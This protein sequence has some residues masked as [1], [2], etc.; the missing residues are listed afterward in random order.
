MAS[1]WQTVRIFISSTFRDMQT[2]R[3]HL[4]RFVFPRLR[5]ELFKWRIHLVDVDL[6]W[7]VTDEQDALEVCREVIDEC[8]LF[9][10]VLG[11]RYGWIPPGHEQSITHDEVT[12]AAFGHPENRNCHFFF[13]RRDHVTNELAKRDA[14]YAEPSGSDEAKQLKQLKDEIVIANKYKAIDYGQWDAAQQ[15]LASLDEFGNEVFNHLLNAIEQ[16]FAGESTEQLDEFAEENAAMDQF[17]S[18]RVERYVPVDSRQ[19]LL[20]DLETFAT[21]D[22]EQNILPITGEPGSGKSALLASYVAEVAKLQTSSEVSRTQ[23]LK[24][25]PHFIGASAGSTDLRRMLRRLCHEL[26]DEVDSIPHETKELIPRFA[27]LLC[28]VP[29]SQRVV[30]VIDALDQ[31]DAT[32]NAHTLFWLPQKEKLPPHVRIIA[33]SLEHPALEALTAHPACR[34]PLVIEPLQPADARAIIHSV[35][36]RYH[37]R[38]EPQQIDLLLAKTDSGNPLYLLAALEELRTLGIYDEIT[39]RIEQLPQRTVD[40]F[41]WILDRLSKD[42]G[43]RDAQGKR[44]G[45]DLVPK[46][47]SLLAVSRYG[48]S[49]VELVG[50]INPHHGDLQGNVAALERLLRSYLMRRGDLLA[51]YHGQ[52][53]F[54]V[55][56]YYLET[57]EQLRKA[58]EEV[59]HFFDSHVDAGP[60]KIQELPWQ[61][62]RLNAWSRLKACLCN[63]EVFL[64]WRGETYEEWVRDADFP[65]DLITY[66]APLGAHYDIRAEMR[67]F[68]DVLSQRWN[69]SIRSLNALHK[70]GS[71]LRCLGLPKD[72]L[73]SY[74]QAL[75][76]FDALQHVSLI[77][78]GRL[79]SSMAL[80]CE[81]IGNFGKA[82]S[83]SH[84]SLKLHEQ[85]PDSSRF[86]IAKCTNNLARLVK[87]R[88]DFAT[89]EAMYVR[90]SDIWEQTEG[91]RSVNL[92][93]TLSNIGSLRLANGDV[94]GAR[95]HFERA[96]KIKEQ[97]VGSDHR[98][99]VRTLKNLAV[100][101]RRGCEI[102]SSERDFRRALTIL[103]VQRTLHDF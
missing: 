28:Y 3:N 74:H 89:A 64:H 103:V 62:L 32:D 8:D 91:S 16:D 22:D 84:A 69:G 95:S 13:F 87:R 61:L 78:K 82:E 21:S 43:F 71:L 24:I 63:P 41:R 52:F 34:E 55:E 93:T 33:S 38:M 35:L 23:L 47:A 39:A 36:K 29:T 37:K 85:A 57:K 53:R 4:V 66:W 2:E 1:T 86:D 73:H 67:R 30:I 27:E 14:V 17:I 98:N 40:L 31:L 42:E 58:R 46:F 56:R 6:R 44:I 9:L 48:L 49:H 75:K 83:L 65:Y 51:F 68:V 96:L 80:A 60:R 45:V 26:G 77:H 100:A 19:S 10:C 70:L 20:N 50:A 18:E 12:Y 94:G 99:L 5:E 79:L 7:G 102:E 92:A 88:G 72:E 97:T 11:G 25:I 15:R 90:A 101:K 54:A 81:S 76:N 59:A